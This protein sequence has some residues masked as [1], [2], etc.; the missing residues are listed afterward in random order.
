REVSGR[1]AGTG[2]SVTETVVRSTID[3]SELTK[4]A[5]RKVART[6]KKASKKVSK[7]AKEVRDRIIDRGEEAVAG[8]ITAAGT[9]RDDALDLESDDDK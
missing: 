5:S 6:A 9:A 1:V 4:D 8:V 7:T 3:A 2:K